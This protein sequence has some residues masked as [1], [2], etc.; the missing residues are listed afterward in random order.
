MTTSCLK[1]LPVSVSGTDIKHLKLTQCLVSFPILESLVSF[2][3]LN[4]D[5]VMT[6]SC[7]SAEVLGNVCVASHFMSAVEN[8]RRLDFNTN[9]INICER[10]PKAF[11]LVMLFA[12]ALNEMY[13]REQTSLYAELTARRS[14]PG[15]TVTQWF[16]SGSSFNRTQHTGNQHGK[17]DYMFS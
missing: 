4:V 16:L 8:T 9:W 6:Y 1:L 10:S 3:L 2:F 7:L 11:P 15:C 14:A 5:V 17:C 13:Q 12:D